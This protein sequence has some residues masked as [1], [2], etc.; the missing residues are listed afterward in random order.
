[1]SK[2]VVWTK[3]WISLS[4]SIYDTHKYFYDVCYFIYTYEN[5]HIY[6]VNDFVRCLKVLFPFVEH[7]DIDPCD[8]WSKVVPLLLLLKH[9]QIMNFS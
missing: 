5:F 8:C 2:F 9:L 6:F 3:L 4:V 1:M 7:H